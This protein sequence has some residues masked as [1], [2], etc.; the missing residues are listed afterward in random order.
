MLIFW[1]PHT[2]VP[3]NA[4]PAV[5]AL[6]NQD[7]MTKLTITEEK[8]SYPNLNMHVEESKCPI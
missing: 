4:L 3:T 1:N 5:G 2:D 7:K 8:H 6:L